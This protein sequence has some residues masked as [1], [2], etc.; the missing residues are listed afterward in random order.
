M[1]LK[2]EVI[3]FA[4]A[5]INFPKTR[6]SERKQKI[7]NLYKQLTGEN[8]K[9]SCGTCYIE[10][11]LKIIK[12]NKMAQCDYLLKPGALLQAF[13][14]SSKTCTNANLT[15][16]LAEW[17]LQNNP[18]V[19]K[20]FSKIPLG[21]PTAIP[22]GITIIPIPAEPIIIVPDKI[23]QTAEVKA[24]ITPE[25]VKSVIVKKPAKRRNK[26]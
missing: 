14:D 20:Y 6:T 24:D 9:V 5:Y 21:A 4:R 10:A 7:R 2:E 17:H 11:L 26:K 3:S 22:A 16:E 25:I 19:E 1:T 8:I 23:I 15:N 18:G 13:S 12:L